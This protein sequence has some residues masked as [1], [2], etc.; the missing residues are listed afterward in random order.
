[1]SARDEILRT[2]ASHRREPVAPVTIPA[3]ETPA[4]DETLAFAEAVA[5]SGGRV[6]RAASGVAAD[7]AAR[8]PDAGPV[9]STVHE[10]PGDV[11]LA[12]VT[13][14]HDLADLGVFACRG[15]LGVAESG[16]L[17][18]PGSA[19][20]HHAAPFLAQHMVV[21][22]SSEAIVRNLHEAYE[23]LGNGEADFGLFVAGPS[24]TAD[25]EQALVTGAH[26]PRSLTVYLD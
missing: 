4:G 22:L 12:A 1:M 8:F 2:V 6:V 7:F 9:A 16:A 13:D 15:R 25:I 24:K 26:G 5:E 21:L 17:W 11:D 14:P 3:F 20:V 10:I 23:R 19:L 18:I